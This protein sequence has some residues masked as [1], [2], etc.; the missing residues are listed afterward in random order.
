MHQNC[1]MNIRH[2]CIRGFIQGQ[3][4][5]KFT[6]C[7]DDLVILGLPSRGKCF[8]FLIKNFKLPLEASCPLH[9]NETPAERL[10]EWP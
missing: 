8:F 3:A 1:Q 5:G 4:P 2:T 10:S 9:V 7:K 6:G